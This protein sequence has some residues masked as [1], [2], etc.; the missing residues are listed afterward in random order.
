MHDS[1]LISNAAKTKRRPFSLKHSRSLSGTLQ[2]ESIRNWPTEQTLI[3]IKLFYI[4]SDVSGRKPK[5]TVSITIN[6]LNKIINFGTK[7]MFNVA[8]EVLV[9]FGLQLA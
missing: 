6:L 4:N 7:D 9:E 3:E 2:D 8:A 5:H 1:Q